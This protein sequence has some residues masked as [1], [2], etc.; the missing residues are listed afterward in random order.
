ML[1]YPFTTVIQIYILKI[2]V[3]HWTQIQWFPRDQFLLS[4]V[5]KLVSAEL[6]DLDVLGLLRCSEWLI[7]IVNDSSSQQ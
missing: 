6:D 3:H 5:N 2:I 1:M 4:D 7:T